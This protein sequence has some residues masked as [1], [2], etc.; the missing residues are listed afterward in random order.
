MDLP[1]PAD[2]ADWSWEMIE[3]LSGQQEG[4][5][6]EFKSQLHASDEESREKWHQNLE[7]EFTAFA[8]ASGG[9][10]V[11]G[12]T[13]DGEPAPFVPPE[14]EV[15]QSV[16]RIVQNTVPLVQLEIPD[17]LH[18]PSPDTDRIAL[19][20][21]VHEATRKPV[22]TGDSAVYV[23]TNDRKSP[24]SREQ[25][26]SM[27]VEQ[28]RRQQAI[29]RLE[30]EIDRF[31]EIVNGHGRG[32]NVHGKAPPDYHLLNLDA[33]KEA[34]RSNTHLYAD[35][36]IKGILTRIFREIQRIEDREVYI[37]RVKEGVVEHHRGE[38]VFQTERAELKDMVER[39]E[40][41]LSTLANEA[42]LQVDLT[43]E[44]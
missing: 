8:N 34:L 3:S 13:D 1:F 21:Y 19:V 5:Y 9:I 26:E 44:S 2:P 28:D 20:V 43:E 4:Q 12:V 18:P 11:F 6:L 32:I 27:F 10:I 31:D 40:I 15:S 16:T 23:R 7:R 17:P 29:R 37:Q 22:L 35:G 42:G 25:M 39:L 33:L 36:T 14:H 41:E 24:M 30:M 38:K